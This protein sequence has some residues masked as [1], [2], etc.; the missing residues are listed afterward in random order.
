MWQDIQGIV[1]LFE[2][3]KEKKKLQINERVIEF[4]ILKIVI[5]VFESWQVLNVIYID[6]F[7]EF[8]LRWLFFF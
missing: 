8:I 2:Y 1:Y 4:F 5:I 3:I 7:L 6:V